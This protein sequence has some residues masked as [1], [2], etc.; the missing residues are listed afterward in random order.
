[1]IIASLLLS[2]LLAI[3]EG[4]RAVLGPLETTARA[5]VVNFTA[6]KFDEASKEF[7]ETLRAVAT[8]SMLADLRRKF[9]APLGRFH[10]ITTIRRRSEDGFRVVEVTCR[11]EKS[12]ASFRVVFDDED[13]IGAI[14]LDPIANEPVD[15]ILEAAAR[16]LLK[17]F[18][19]RNF[20]AVPKHFDKNLRAQLPPTR[21]ASL[22]MQVMNTFGAFRSVKGVRQITDETYRT[23][24]LTT[25]F[26]R[27]PVSVRVAF[28]DF[29]E[30]TGLVI[31]SI[32]PEPQRH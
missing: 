3:N 22:Q 26:E 14:H 13:H 31:G 20:E 23:I 24:D 28:N 8:P 1:M 25:E 30:V 29:G 16:E 4:P 7:N 27:S 17:N 21:L 2:M 15:P 19:A 32:T 9:D 18:I 6:S 11:F 5:F 12:L 10:F